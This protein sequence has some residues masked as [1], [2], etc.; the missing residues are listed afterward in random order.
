MQG[1]I[2]NLP[3]V[4]QLDW[5]GVAGVVAMAA[6]SRLRLINLDLS[7]FA[8]KQDYRYSPATPYSSRGVGMSIFPTINLAPNATVRLVGLWLGAPSIS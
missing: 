5:A 3:K 4:Q 8:F 1:N 2:I 7:N 6:G